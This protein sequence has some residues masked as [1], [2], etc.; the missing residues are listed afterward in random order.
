[1][2]TDKNCFRFDT[3]YK[4]IGALVIL[5]A[6]CHKDYKDTAEGLYNECIR[7]AELLK[8]PLSQAEYE[9]LVALGVSE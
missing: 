9:L 7:R 3:A 6:Y 8:Y 2:M 5:V 1:M 4:I